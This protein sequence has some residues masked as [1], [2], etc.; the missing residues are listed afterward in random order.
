VLAPQI[1]D[2]D[3]AFT[4]CIKGVIKE[5]NIT[6]IDLI[7]MAK[8]TLDEDAVISYYSALNKIT[9]MRMEKWHVWIS[10]ILHMKYELICY[11]KNRKILT[12]KYPEDTFETGIVKY[13]N[14]GNKNDDPFKKTVKKIMVMENITKN[15]LKS[16]EVDDYTINN[17]IT[18][19]NS[20]KPL[21][22]QLFSRFVRMTNISYRIKIYNKDGKMIFQYKE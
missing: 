11:R 18:T 4:Q 1:K 9:F 16:D 15:D 6:I 5:L 14:I 10:I 19:I 12:Y 13:D 20:N 7:D 8:P 3:N 22:S 17:M 21:S 2:A